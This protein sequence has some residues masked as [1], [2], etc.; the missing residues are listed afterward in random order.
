MGASDRREQAHHE[1]M[2]AVCPVVQQ[3]GAGW[4]QRCL[5]GS[6]CGGSS[7]AQ[8]AVHVVV[9]AAPQQVGACGGI[10]D[11]FLAWPTT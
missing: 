6:A 11:N 9:V 7:A 3:V 4:Q 8:Q 5:A 10:A 2:K 1:Y